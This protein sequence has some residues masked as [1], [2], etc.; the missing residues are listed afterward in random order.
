MIR[1]Q[2]V[3]PKTVRSNDIDNVSKET[4]LWEVDLSFNQAFQ[5]VN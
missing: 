5:T 4:L 3:S 1:C 2:R